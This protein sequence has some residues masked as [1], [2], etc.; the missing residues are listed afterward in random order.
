MPT[1]TIHELKTWPTPFQALWD[2]TKT[3]ELRRNDRDFKPGDQLYLREWT[4][5]H[6]SPCHW[7]SDTDEL[8]TSREDIHCV[9]CR[10]G[11]GEPLKGDFTDREILAQVTYVLRA[12]DFPGLEKGFAVLGIAVK[13]KRRIA[14]VDPRQIAF[15]WAV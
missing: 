13:T 2:G 11:I 7:R 15:A 4:P 5:P 12:G 9:D 1:M 10:R 8:Q 14:P 6:E 3:F